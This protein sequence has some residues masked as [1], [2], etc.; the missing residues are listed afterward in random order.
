MTGI[1]S[2]MNAATQSQEKFMMSYIGWFL[3]KI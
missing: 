3:M 2:A 1:I